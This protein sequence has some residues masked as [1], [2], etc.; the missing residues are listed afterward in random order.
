MTSFKECCKNKAKS[1]EC[2]LTIGKIRRGENHEFLQQ[3]I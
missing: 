1:I 3:K 2:Y